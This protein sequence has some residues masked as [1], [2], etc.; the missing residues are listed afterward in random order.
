MAGEIASA[1]LTIYPKLDGKS[2]VD[3]IGKTMGGA[4][5]S[6]GRTF[7]ADASA[8]LTRGMGSAGSAGSN[9]LVD[10]FSA[11]KVVIGNIIADIAESAA[12]EFSRRFGDGIEQSDALQKFAS[13]MKFAGFDTKQIEAVRDA[14][15][16]YADQTVYDLGEVM[17]TTAKLAANGVRDFDSLVQASGNLNAAAGGNSESFGYFANAITQVNGAGKLMAQDW[18]QIVNALPGASGAIQKELE[19]MGAWDSSLMDFKEAMSNGEISAEEFNAAIQNLG[20]TD[21]AQE[22]ATSTTTFEGAMGQLDASVTNTMQGIYDSLNEDG[23]ITDAI[24]GM[25]EAFE[26]VAPYVGQLADAFGDFVEFISP[27]LPVIAGIVAGIAAASVIG[28]II[29]AIVGAVTM[30]TTVVGPALAMVGSVPGLIAL[31]MSVLGGPI[32]VIAAVVGAIVAFVATNEDARNALINAWNAVK[33]FFA[34]IPEWW[35]NVWGMVTEKIEAAKNAIEVQW[36]T[37]KDNAARVFDNIK[38]TISNAMNNAK[39]A[40][41]NA[42]ASMKQGVTAK[43]NEIVSFIK[44]IPGKIRSALSGLGSLLLSAGRSIISGLFN[45]IKEKAQA[46]FDYVSGIAGKIKSLKGPLPYDLKVLVPNGM[47]LMEGL[48]NGIEGGYDKLVSPYV[49]EIAGNIGALSGATVGYGV[50]GTLPAGG[51]VYNVYLNDLAVNDDAGI[52]TVTRGYLMDLARLG[53][54]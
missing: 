24:N 21:V 1:Y 50:H 6:A 40:L 7:A 33:E 38:T 30:L 18:N 49:S 3:E 46:V 17:D 10:G 34:G 4:G 14:M 2:V 47:A 19:G 44:G 45:G 20:L 42:V 41:T 52:V 9:A 35:S 12:S 51:T 29:S 53:A 48:R 23:R 32:T 11:A 36:N 5:K 26:A 16:D 39:T 31:V 28:G 37:I 25:A 8:E 13:T 15:K 27:A 54:I 43:F 22:A